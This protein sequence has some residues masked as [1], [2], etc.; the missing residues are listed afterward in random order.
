MVGILVVSHGRLAEALISSVQF[1]VGNLKRVKGISIWPRDR[2]EE[3]KDR[4]QKGIGEVDDGDGVVIL[5]D[6]LGGTPTNL[7]LSVLENKQVEVVT[8]VNLPMLLTLSSYRKEKSLREIGRLVKKSG[9]RSIILAKELL[10]SK[11][12]KRW[13]T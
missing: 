4:I 6:V 3:V 2:K 7:T 10:G 11:G 13:T 9:R 5:T 1:L 8:G 12:G